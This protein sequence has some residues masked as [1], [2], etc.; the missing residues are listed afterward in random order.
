[1]LYIVHWVN[2]LS[3]NPHLLQFLFRQEQVLAARPGFFDVDRRKKSALGKLAVQV[4]FHVAR[5]LELF[6][7]DFVHSAAG[8][9]ERSSDDRQRSAAFDIPCRAKESLR[10][11]QCVGIHTTGEYFTRSR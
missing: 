4:Y 8:L 7:N 5:T 3:Q 2:D 9:N 10:F 1:D 11:V 6:E